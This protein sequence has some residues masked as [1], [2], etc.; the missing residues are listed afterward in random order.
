MGA[1]QA[2]IAVFS[3][4]TFE[5]VCKPVMP[6]LWEAEIGRFQIRVY[7]GQ[8]SDLER[9]FQSKKY[10]KDCAIGL[11]SISI[12]KCAH[13]TFCIAFINTLM[14]ISGERATVN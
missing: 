7:A 9:L 1:M 10:K 4:F 11:G 2:K 13:A 12:T 6:A 8:Y 3:I 5:L 14:G